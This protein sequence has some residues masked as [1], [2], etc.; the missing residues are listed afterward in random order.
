M[1]RATTRNYFGSQDF[2]GSFRLGLLR[3]RS[4]P[5]PCYC[6]PPCHN[7]IALGMRASIRSFRCRHPSRLISKLPALSSHHSIPIEAGRACLYNGSHHS[8][9]QPLSLLHRREYH[10]T[11]F[12]QD[13]PTIYALSTASGKAAI[14][15]IRVSG[16]ACR[17]V[18]LFP[19]SSQLRQTESMP[20]IQRAMSLD[21]LPKATSCDSAQALQPASPSIAF[22]ATRCRCSRFI[23][24]CT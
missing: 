8:I 2:G 17:Q 1:R 22:D 20:D 12:C 19:S 11:A 15:V 16:A 4:E 24:S 9:E 5:P 6:T 14:A 13:E 21:S 23:L 7:P 18:L 3:R 10:P